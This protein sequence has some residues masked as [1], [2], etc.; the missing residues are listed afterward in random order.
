MEAIVTRTPRG[1]RID[2]GVCFAA[3]EYD[4]GPMEMHATFNDGSEY[5]F[6][7]ITPDVA[8]DWLS[9]G[10]PG[11]YFNRSIYPGTF[12]KIHGPTH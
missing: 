8:A 6:H 7:G 4:P 3:L 12:T 2:N 5:V 11:C 9:A 10:D 1:C